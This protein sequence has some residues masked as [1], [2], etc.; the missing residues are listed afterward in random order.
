MNLNYQDT[1]T[2]ITVESNGYGNDKSVTAQV[3]VPVIFVQNTGFRH[4][5]NQDAIE[6][7]AVCW[8]DP[9]NSFIQSNFNRLEGMYILEPLFGASDDPSWYKI[10]DVT[11]NRDHLL[12]NEINN[13]ELKLKKTVAIAGV[14]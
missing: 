10:I 14:S 3:E 2:F 11:V 12:Q 6:S 7:D 5:N 13:I 9:E 4:A 1:A 8:P